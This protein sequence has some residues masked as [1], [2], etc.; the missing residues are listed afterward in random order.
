[1]SLLNQKTLKKSASFRGVG[2]HNGQLTKVCIK[3]AEPNS[4]I[5]FKRIDLKSNNYVYPIFTNV[6]IHC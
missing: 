3:P 1:M 5:I 2:L 4:G 6:T